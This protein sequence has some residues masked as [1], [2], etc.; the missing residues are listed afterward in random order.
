MNNAIINRELFYQYS[1]STIIT[2]DIFSEVENLIN[3]EKLD[4]KNFLNLSEFIENVLLNKANFIL[5]YDERGNNGANLF[6][7]LGANEVLKKIFTVV[8]IM[9]DDDVSKQEIPSWLWSAGVNDVLQTITEEKSDKNTMTLFGRYEKGDNRNFDF[10]MIS[11][12]ILLNAGSE[13]RSELED[14]YDSLYSLQRKEYPKTVAKII[15]ITKVEGENVL[16]YSNGFTDAF[17]RLEHFLYSQKLLEENTG[18]YVTNDILK[19]EIYETF[20]NANLRTDKKLYEAIKNAFKSD[21]EKIKK[22]SGA[23]KTYVPPFTAIILSRSNDRDDIPGQIVKAKI[24][25]NDLIELEDKYAK[26]I[27]NQDKSLKERLDLLDEY[28]RMQKILVKQ[29]TS[30]PE[31]KTIYRFWDVIKSFNP[32]QITQNI[33]EEIKNG[34]QDFKLRYRIKPC[35]GLYKKIGKLRQYEALIRRTFKSDI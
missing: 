20:N 8:G 28:E 23:I 17:R 16:K 6:T 14:K 2:E 11:L 29:I 3:G 26:Q 25:F 18:L 10:Q 15:Q 5:S 35:V 21:I 12:Q 7:Y 33:V 4:E 1:N 31:E 9:N 34:G 32:I 19:G 13:F 24:E 22:Y 27:S 30:R